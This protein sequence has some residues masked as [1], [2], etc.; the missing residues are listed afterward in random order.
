MLGEG[1]ACRALAGKR[2]HIRG[3]GHGA[4]GGDLVLARRTLEFFERQLHLVNEPYRAFRVLAIELPRQLLD[5]HSLMRDQGG[6]VRSLGLGNRQF[7][8]GSRRPDRLVDALIALG[9]QRCLQ[10]F[11]MFRQVFMGRRHGGIES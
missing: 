11:D 5:L 3:L 7:R 8:L 9:N 4:L 1:L 10:R 6:I 2:H